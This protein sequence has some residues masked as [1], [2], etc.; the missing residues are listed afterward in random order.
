MN[1]NMYI[2]PSATDRYTEGM[3]THCTSVSIHA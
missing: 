1:M 2:Y 3:D